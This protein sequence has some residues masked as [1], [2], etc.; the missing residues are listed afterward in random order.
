MTY[1]PKET[2]KAARTAKG[3]YPASYSTF[4]MNRSYNAQRGRRKRILARGPAGAFFVSGKVAMTLAALIKHG[5]SGITA[6][7]LSNSWALRLAAY[8][9]QLRQYGLEIET[10]RESHDDIGGWHARYALHSAVAMLGEI[11]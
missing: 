11:G 9:H 4:G 5:Q 2:P 7:E 1:Q 8:V 6:L 3:V 10:I